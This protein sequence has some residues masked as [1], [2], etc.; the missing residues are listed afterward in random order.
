[1]ACVARQSPR[2]N[3][4]SI[5]GGRGQTWQLC[6]DCSCLTV[7]PLDMVAEAIKLDACSILDESASNENGP[8]Q[9]LSPHRGGSLRKR[10]SGSP[11]G[12][13]KR[14]LSMLLSLPLLL[15]LACSMSPLKKCRGLYKGYFGSAVAFAA[16]AY[17]HT[18]QQL[19]EMARDPTAGVR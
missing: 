6:L 19:G 4:L 11:R 5:S 1:M 7:T 18:A 12:M 2:A 15:Q 17:R 8:P 16:K 10:K 14:T 3:F 13:S 9:L